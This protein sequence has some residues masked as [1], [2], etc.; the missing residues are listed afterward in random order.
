LKT[1]SAA[2]RL[3]IFMHVINLIQFTKNFSSL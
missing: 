1:S 2:F 3:I